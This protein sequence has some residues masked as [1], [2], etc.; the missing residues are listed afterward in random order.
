M[1]VAKKKVKIPKL[2]ANGKDGKDDHYIVCI[3]ASAGGMEAIHDLFDNMPQDTGYSFIVIQHLSSEYKSLMA[4]LL[5]KHTTMNVAEAAD[6]VLVQPNTVYVIPNNRNITIHDRHLKL[7]AKEERRSPNMAIDIF[8][9]SLAKDVGKKAIAIILSGTGSDGTKG[10]AAIK[11]A[12][13]LVF[14]QDPLSSKFDGMPHSAIASGKIDYIL[15][16]ESIA[17][18]LVTRHQVALPAVIVDSL[19]AEDEPVLAEILNLLN[20]RTSCDFTAYKR[21]TLVRRLTRRMGMLNYKSPREYL[22]FLKS[23]D[24]EINALCKEFLIG[25]TRFFRDPEAFEELKLKVI[26]E[27]VKSKNPGEMIK[28]WVAGCSTG[29][30]VYSIAILFREHFSRIKKSFD[31]KIF[32]SDVNKESTE[33]ASKGVYSDTIARDIP[34]DLLEK[35]F[36]KEKNKYRV[37]SQIRKMIVFSHHDLL[38]DAPFGRLDLICCRNMLIYVA[39]ELQKRIMAIFHFSLNLGGYLF[40]GSSEN[41]GDLKDSVIEVSKK[42]KIYKNT[43]MAKSMGL[44]TLAYSDALTRKFS[45]TVKIH[46]EVSRKAIIETLVTIMMDE[47]TAAGALVDKHCTV[48][49]TFGDYRKYLQL[50]EK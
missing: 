34:R 37:S 14:V 30:E 22:E 17:E 35:Y 1:K 33:F 18:E 24:G 40:M 31:I 21:P 39:P 45:P 44:D 48:I 36:T 50:P 16:P 32:A 7:T 8:L 13:G 4:E 46:K 2:P 3:G 28:V 6:G 47:Y 12:G 27:I 41:I 9:H 42:W 49:E 26:P 29:E 23:D 10:I 38:R 25:V 15:S 19:P 5:A 11:K 43:R 20:R